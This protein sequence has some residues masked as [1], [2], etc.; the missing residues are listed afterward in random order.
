M[1]NAAAV[2]GHLRSRLDAFTE[3]HK[4]V[5]EVRG[6]GLMQ[7]IELV[8]DKDQGAGAAAAAAVM[9]AAKDRGLIIGK[10]GLY[11]N[12]LRISPAL[13]VTRRTPTR[14]PT[15]WTRPWRRAARREHVPRRAG[16]G[17]GGSCPSCGAGP[18]TDPRDGRRWTAAASPTSS[19]SARSSSPTPRTSRCAPSATGSCTS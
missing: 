15:S 5:G 13:N 19:G 4:T 2:G 1:D 14:P 10:G 9:E 16:S 8:K 12:V 11:G 18:A 6:M 17:P 7:G 3:K